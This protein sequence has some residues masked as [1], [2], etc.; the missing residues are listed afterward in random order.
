MKL[1]LGLGIE[2]KNILGISNV[3]KIKNSCTFQKGESPE[4]DRKK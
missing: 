4:K 2:E 3:K 1:M